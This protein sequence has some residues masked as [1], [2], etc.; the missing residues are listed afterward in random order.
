[1]DPSQTC[2]LLLSHV[3]TSNL[4]FS[5]IE[6]P[7]SVN[8]SIKKTFIKNKKGEC[9]PAGLIPSNI[10]EMSFLD[11]NRNLV[12]ENET[13]K[14]RINKIESEKEA[15]EEALQ[16]VGTKLERAQVEVCELLAVNSKKTK[17]MEKAEKKLDEIENKSTELKV[18]TDRLETEIEIK[19][20]EIAKIYSKNK[21][22][23]ETLNNTKKEKDEAIKEKNTIENKLL[24]LKPQNFKTSST[25]TMT[26]SLSSK[27]TNTASTSTSS[28]ST[29]TFYCPDTSSTSSVQYSTAKNSDTM[30]L[31]STFPSS[32]SSTN[33]NTGTSTSTPCCRTHPWN[34]IPLSIPSK[35]NSNCDH[36][37][38]C[39]IRKPKPPPSVTFLVN[40]QSNYHEHILT[41]VPGRYG[42]CERCFDV[43]N[44]NYG[45]PD[46]VWLKWHGDLHGYPDVNPWSFKKYLNPEEWPALN[47][48]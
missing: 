33:P 21:S 19:G 41:R 18:A 46:C 15:F 20:N 28:K 38:Q 4:N 47:L 27:S 32:T 16:N 10:I 34:N 45:C 17:A 8:I 36:P 31:M 25:S 48:G 9:L 35:S 24:K 13:L 5:L 22:L 23:I 2:D 40:H 43:E 11:S 6:S 14:G 26:N 3:K 29:N 39:T 12:K 37:S 1:M 30:N 44:K 42:G 7:F